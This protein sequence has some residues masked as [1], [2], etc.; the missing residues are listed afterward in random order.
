MKVKSSNKLTLFNQAPQITLNQS[1]VDLKEF[2]Q[3]AKNRKDKASLQQDVSIEVKES[4]FIEFPFRHISA[5]IV[6]AGGWQATDFSNEKVLKKAVPL[7]KGKPAYLNHDMDVGNEV[8]YIGNT[9]WS[10]AYINSEGFEIPAGINAPFVIDSV[11]EPALI[12]KMSGPNPYVKSASITVKF[13]WE[14]SHEFNDEWDFYWSLGEMREDETG[15][16]SMVR[17]I[18]TQINEIY[19]SSLV[20][21]GADPYAGILDANGE[22]KFINKAGISF[23]KAD[24]SKITDEQVELLKKEYFDNNHYFVDVKNVESFNHNSMDKFKE[25]IAQKLGKKPEEINLEMI[26]SSFENSNKLEE[27]TKAFSTLTDSFNTLTEKS[28]NLENSISEM[29][30]TNSELSGKVTSLESDNSILKEEKVSLEGTLEKLQKSVGS[31]L[32]LQRKE[33]IKFYKLSI[34]NNNASNLII[35]ELENETNLEV[36]SAKTES[37]GGLVVNSFGATCNDC[38]SKE[39]NFRSSKESKQGNEDDEN[40]SFIDPVLAAQTGRKY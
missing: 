21:L 5:T 26:A 32:D 6:G 7:L 8:G 33:A 35:E 24:D 31:V 23:A 10:K 36:L 16:M 19:E 2:A 34:G 17:R 14:A 15:E 30:A 25:L 3:F 38:N 39:I 27:Q 11:L 28:T 37:Y 12:R 40:Y 13:D 20:W 22:V 4:D 1:D 29:K 18:V 9:K